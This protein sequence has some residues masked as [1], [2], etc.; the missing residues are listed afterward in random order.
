LLHTTLLSASN[1]VKAIKEDARREAEVTLR[2]AR[3]VAERR[4]ALAEQMERD[5][6]AA[7]RELARLRA[8]AQ[9]MQAG[10]AGFLTTTLEQLQIEPQDR[11]PEPPPSGGVHEVLA[12][13]LEDTVRREGG[14]VAPG[15][16]GVSPAPTEL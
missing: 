1:H 14:E 11:A 15:G 6:E 16:G 9:E 8:L 13:A 12:G 5:R 10:L 2:K 3:A 7:E 4:T